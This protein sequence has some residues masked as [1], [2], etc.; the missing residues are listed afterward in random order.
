LTSAGTRKSHHLYGLAQIR[1]GNGPVV[2]VEG[3]TDVWR[4]GYDAVAILGK[5]MSLQQRQRLLEIAEGR[6]I[7][8]ALDPDASVNAHRA[9]EQLVADRQQAGDVSPVVFVKLPDGR[10]DIG[11]CT[12]DEAWSA[13]TM[14]VDAASPNA[15][16]SRQSSAGLA[17]ILIDGKRRRLTATG[18]RRIGERVVVDYGDTGASNPTMAIIGDDHKV[19]CVTSG[20]AR[21]LGQL[22]GRKRIY[23]NSVTA[24]LIED[25]GQLPVTEDFEDLRIIAR[26][27]DNQHLLEVIG[28][29]RPSSTTGESAR[30]IGNRNGRHDHSALAEQVAIVRRAWD[31][32]EPL[33][34]LCDEGLAFVYEHIEKPIVGATAAM[35]QN[36]ML[37]DVPRL[38]QL[39]GEFAHKRDQLQ[40]NIDQAVGCHVNIA[41]HQVL[42]AA[43]YEQLHLPVICRNR[44]NSPS[45]DADTLRHLAPQYPVAQQVLDWRKLQSNYQYALR[46]RQAVCADTGRIH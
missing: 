16:S 40:T 15:V 42:S 2:L 34:H 18:L 12:R 27:T 8:V 44:D 33:Q 7:A 10:E 6:A 26:L 4:L 11:E 38:G 31:D 1:D 39:I 17:S 19:R 14:A 35:I 5:D 45:T 21:I 46:L 23:A 3:P 29:D 22:A 32:G 9:R 37:V 36:G 43:L 28:G 20:Q 24:R 13:V 41:S 25:Q 30:S